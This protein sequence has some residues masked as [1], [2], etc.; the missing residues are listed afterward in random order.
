MA[1]P[2]SLP[3]DGLIDIVVQEQVSLLRLLPPPEPRVLFCQSTRK[4]MFAC[5]GD[6]AVKGETYWLK[7]VWMKN[8]AGTI[9]YTL[10]SNTISKHT[11]I[12]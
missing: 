10:C 1:F 5:I 7:S 12:E 3:D 4:E 9:A 8:I 11:R 6:A 2:V